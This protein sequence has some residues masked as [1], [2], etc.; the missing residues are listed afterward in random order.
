[1]LDLFVD[2]GDAVVALDKVAVEVF[3]GAGADVVVEVGRERVD[4]EAD[5]VE[6]GVDPGVHHLAG[7]HGDVGVGLDAELF[8]G[9]EVVD[10]IDVVGVEGLLAEE[11]ELD[12]ARGACA[13][14]DGALEDVAGHESVLAVVRGAGGLGVVVLV[15]L[16]AEGAA[17]VADVGQLDGDEQALGIGEDG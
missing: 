10:V 15:G 17:V 16:G 14:I 7:E 2:G 9:A 12:A 13:F 1:M 5:H 8:V 3:A 11:T 6:L 4:G